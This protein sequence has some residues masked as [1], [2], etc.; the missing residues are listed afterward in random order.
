VR[1]INTRPAWIEVAPRALAGVALGATAGGLFGGIEL[2]DIQRGLEAGGAAGLI[3]GLSVGILIRR[4]HRGHKKSGMN[5]REFMDQ[6]TNGGG[7]S[8][9][10][11]HAARR[12]IDLT[13]NEGH[14]EALA[15]TLF[16]QIIQRTQAYGSAVQ[17][18]GGSLLAALQGGGLRRRSLGPPLRPSRLRSVAEVVRTLL[19]HPQGQSC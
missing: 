7:E 5:L 11:S 8:P 1:V 18:A 17:R 15:A 19:G 2:H 3:G 4:Q 16:W 6:Y 10:A 9:L 13:R 14:A 12:L